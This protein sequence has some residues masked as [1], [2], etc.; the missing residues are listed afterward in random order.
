MNI[1]IIDEL[2]PTNLD[3]LREVEKIIGVELPEEYKQFLLSH[4]GGYPEPNVFR[5]QWSG[6][7]W[8]EG[9]EINSIAW[10]LAVYDG[11]DMNFV[12]FYETHKDRIPKDTVAIADDPGSNLILLGTSGPNKG[13]VFFWQRDYEVD[14]QNGEVPDYSNVGFVSNS[15]NEFIDSLF[16]L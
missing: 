15:F 11:K 1:K 5:V 9:N 12:D 6:Q 10:F 16:E 2:H 8:A 3:Q 7:Y 13:K 4:N 14:F